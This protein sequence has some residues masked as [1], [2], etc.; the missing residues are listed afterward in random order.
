MVSEM[1]KKEAE[2]EGERERERERETKREGERRER[3]RER[4]RKSGRLINIIKTIS[5][6]SPGEYITSYIGRQTPFPRHLLSQAEGRKQTGGDSGQGESDEEKGASCSSSE[7]DPT[8]EREELK[9]KKGRLL[10][11]GAFGK[12]NDT[13]TVTR[14]TIYYSLLPPSPRCGRASWTLLN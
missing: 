9:W 4:E 11:K 2:S 10:G 5:C 1:I 13:L 6:Y 7:D 12:V 3:E 14:L 8:E